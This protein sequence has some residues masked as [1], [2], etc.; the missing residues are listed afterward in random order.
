MTR[1]ELAAGTTCLILG[2]LI[3]VVAP[4]SRVMLLTDP[5]VLGVPLAIGVPGLGYLGMA[6]GMLWMLRIAR[7]G[8]EDGRPSIWRYRDR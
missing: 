4:P 2:L 3:F 7:R 5:S 1:F 6:V 8:P